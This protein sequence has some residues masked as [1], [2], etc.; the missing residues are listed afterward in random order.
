LFADEV[1]Q[2]YIPL[3]LMQNLLRSR[4]SRMPHGRHIKDERKEIRIGNLS[5][6]GSSHQ[7]GDAAFTPATPKDLQHSRANTD[8]HSTQHMKV[9]TNAIRF[10]HKDTQPIQ[11][12]SGGQ[13][14]H[15][16]ADPKSMRVK[17]LCFW[18]VETRLVKKL[19]MISHYLVVFIQHD[20]GELRELKS[21]TCAKI[22]SPLYFAAQY[23]GNWIQAKPTLTS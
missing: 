9:K 21:G 7:T 16:K 14:H 4:L 18:G 3:G 13:S 17:P 15:T 5:L 19:V 10:V 6:D 12:C 20:P 22:E 2:G 8:S 23:K 1:T 11:E